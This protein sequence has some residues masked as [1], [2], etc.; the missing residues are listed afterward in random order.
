MAKMANKEDM[1]QLAF[2]YERICQII[3]YFK[4]ER[5]RDEDDEEQMSEIPSWFDSKFISSPKHLEE[6][7]DEK[8]KTHFLVIE[9]CTD[10]KMVKSRTPISEEESATLQGMADKNK[11]PFS[12]HI[13][14]VLSRFMFFPKSAMSEP[15]KMVK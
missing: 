11:H 1:A 12:F 14:R 10:G 8:S 4:S 13:S 2:H 15:F 5:D 9:Q 6:N 7:Y 3:V